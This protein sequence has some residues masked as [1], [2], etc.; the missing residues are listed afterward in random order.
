MQVC[1]TI[2]ENTQSAFTPDIDILAPMIL[3]GTP[4]DWNIVSIAQPN[5]CQRVIP[6]KHRKFFSNNSAASDNVTVSIPRSG[7]SMVSAP[8]VLRSQV[9]TRSQAI[10]REPPDL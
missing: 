5:L 8:E 6:K 10:G 9:T 7:H 1:N 3:K 2:D 4:L